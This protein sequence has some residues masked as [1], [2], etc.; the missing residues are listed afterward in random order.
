M[1]EQRYL[2]HGD[3]PYNQIVKNSTASILNV[4]IDEPTYQAWFTNDLTV[5][6]T[7][8]NSPALANVG[9][10]AIQFPP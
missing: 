6:I 1:T 2:D 5:N 10:S 8:P 3:D 4:L 7:D 9:R